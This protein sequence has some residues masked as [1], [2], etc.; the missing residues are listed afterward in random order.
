MTLVEV[1]MSLL[2][3]YRKLIPAA[4]L[5]TESSFTIAFIWRPIRFSCN[6][7]LG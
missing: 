5:K 3:V 2:L 6:W 4:L 1:V 7:V